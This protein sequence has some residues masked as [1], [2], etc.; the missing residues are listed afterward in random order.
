MSVLL[1]SN[2]EKASLSQSRSMDATGLTMEDVSS[3]DTDAILETSV[4]GSD[5]VNMGG[6]FH[7]PLFKD[8]RV[9]KILDE[10][11]KKS[12]KKSVSSSVDRPIH[13]A[14]SRMGQI[15]SSP[16]KRDVVYSERILNKHRLFLNGQYD[17]S[18]VGAKSRAIGSI[19]MKFDSRFVESQSKLQADEI[20]RTSSSLK[21]L[22]SKMSVGNSGLQLSV[23][24]HVYKQPS[25]SMSTKSLSTKLSSTSDFVGST[26]GT[27]LETYPSK[28][29][30]LVEI[31]SQRTSGYH[32]DVLSPDHRTFEDREIQQGQPILSGRRIISTGK[33]ASILRKDSSSTDILMRQPPIGTKVHQRSKTWGYL[34]S[35][36]DAAPD[37]SSTPIRRPEY[38]TL[39]PSS[40]KPSGFPFSATSR[41]SSIAGRMPPSSNPHSTSNAR[42]YSDQTSRTGH[43]GFVERSRLGDSTFSPRSG[44]SYTNWKSS[45]STSRKIEASLREE[46]SEEEER[47]PTQEYVQRRYVADEFQ[48]KSKD[49]KVADDAREPDFP[50]EA[51]NEH[52]RTWP[53]IERM[54][55][56]SRTAYM[57]SKRNGVKSSYSS[58]TA[59]KRSIPLRPQNPISVATRMVSDVPLIPSFSTTD[60][61]NRHQTTSSAVRPQKSLSGGPSSR[62]STFTAKDSRYFSDDDNMTTDTDLL[63]SQP[64]MPIVNASPSVSTI[65]DE[66]ATIQNDS[67]DSESMSFADLPIRSSSRVS[68]AP[69]V[70]FSRTSGVSPLSKFESTNPRTA[71]AHL[72]RNSINKSIQKSNHNQE[73]W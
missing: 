12:K 21:N 48:V 73:F 55:E 39:G 8:S 44:S 29:S 26:H 67:S 4:Y 50:F 43:P 11:R 25:L 68:F 70:S 6:N 36:K 62:H 37:A 40:V 45:A 31:N 47:L 10:S 46:E 53:S 42:S 63:L 54:K 14:A 60:T 69:D 18:T 30:D 2:R 13:S 52:N 33:R 35:L 64:P 23:G 41:V 5:P 61:L 56:R 49:E 28:S 1:K 17:K 9:Q 59:E 19:D 20:M 34:Q 65:S 16:Q 57:K 3:I 72:L 38:R 58:W 66:D 7:Q 24:A 15:I 71:E 27:A 32:S 51:L 22:P